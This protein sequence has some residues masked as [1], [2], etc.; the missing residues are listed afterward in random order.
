MNLIYAINGENAVQ[1]VEACGELV[2]V[3]SDGLR[4][5]PSRTCSQRDCVGLRLFLRVRTVPL[6]R[7]CRRKAPPR[8]VLETTTHW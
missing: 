1:L 3:V 8:V 6:N 2:V 4:R 7:E 5:C